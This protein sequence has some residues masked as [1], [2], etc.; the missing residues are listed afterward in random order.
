M[1]KKKGDAVR[2]KKIEN[3][4][5]HGKVVLRAARPFL[6]WAGGKQR[7]AG[8]LL[9]FVPQVDQYERY[10]EPF[11]GGG[12][13]FFA[14]QPERAILSDLNRELINCYRQVRTNPKVVSAM[15]RRYAKRDSSSFFYEIRDGNHNA[16]TKSAKAARFI[17]LNK[18]AFNGIYR[19]NRKGK[20]NVPY[21]PSKNG[22]A[23]PS[24]E[25]LLAASGCLKG[26]TMLTG[27]FEEVLRKA[28]GGDFVYL[29]PPYPPRSDTAYFVHYSADRFSWDQQ[30][31]VAEV[32]RSL[33]KR[34]CLVM[35]SNADQ[36]K[37][38][39]LYK[40]FH[41]HRL[42]ATRWLGS[43]GDRF[44][45]REIVVTNYDPSKTT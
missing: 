16:R 22:P 25:A 35:M 2:R 36:K 5:P 44:R 41:V 20:F 26:A 3:S 42:N 13:V 28:K 40:G 15:V 23:V 10:F 17:Y 1:A 29:D 8:S 6:R 30:L 37:V 11:F 39:S 43:N 33:S 18:A 4:S 21:G 24:C 9:E 19:V 34:R 45:V 32:F 12:A 38:V 31:R 7:L 27:D 14:I